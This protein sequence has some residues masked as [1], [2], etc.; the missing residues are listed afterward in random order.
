MPTAVAGEAASAQ[1]CLESNPGRSGV[2]A[3]HRPSISS[4]KC[5]VTPAAQ[6][7]ADCP[8]PGVSW[9][10][11]SSSSLPCLGKLY[12]GKASLAFLVLQAH[13]LLLAGAALAPCV[14]QEQ[15]Q[16]WQHAVNM[17]RW[18]AGMLGQRIIPATASKSES[19]LLSSLLPFFSN[20][21]WKGDGSLLQRPTH[22][23][24][25]WW[26]VLAS[27]EDAGMSL[28]FST[29]GGT[30]IR[31]LIASGWLVWDGTGRGGRSY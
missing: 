28:M 20:P 3:M 7:K 24:F 5:Y 12:E 9:E 11:G 15:E 2:G 18:M 23:F 13:T 4:R 25:T 29:P 21:A 8:V 16:N 6:K 26:Y 22:E 17:G 27:R 14:G 10:V 19:Q 31:G 1:C 30:G